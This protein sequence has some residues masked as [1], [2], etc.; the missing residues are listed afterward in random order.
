MEAE[1]VE[2]ESGVPSSLSP[3]KV[4]GPLGPEVNICE[5]E[6]EKSRFLTL[7]QQLFTLK[8]I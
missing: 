3:Y 8:T 5:S 6:S 7:I 2:A 4:S 1:S